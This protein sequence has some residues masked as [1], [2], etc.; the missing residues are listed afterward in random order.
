MAMKPLNTYLKTKNNTRLKPRIEPCGQYQTIA[1]LVL[2]KK[3]FF[4]KNQVQ[5]SCKPTK[6]KSAEF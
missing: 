2:K 3:P 4:W 5:S 6:I 1:K